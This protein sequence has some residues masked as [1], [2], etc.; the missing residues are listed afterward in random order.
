MIARPSPIRPAAPL[1]AAAVAACVALVT[2]AHPAAATES[3]DVPLM[4]TQGA[5]APNVLII[6]DS[7]GSMAEAIYHPEYD[8]S[9]S[10]S[11]NFAALTGYSVAAT[12][13]F[14][15][16]SWNAGWPAAPT[17][18]LAASEAGRAGRYLGNYL[19]W[20]FFHATDAQRASLPQITRI[21][22]GK[23]AVQ[24]I[25]S[26]SSG[27][28]FG[29][30]RFNGSDG[31]TLVSPLGSDV[32]SILTAMDGIRADS[33]TPSAET[34]VDALEYFQ[35]NG[36]GA[37]IQYEC[38]D[39]SIVFVTDGYPTQDLDV[40]AYIGDPDHD[41]AEPGNCSSIGAPEPDGNN[42]S[43]WMDD[44]AFYLAHQDLR[45]DLDGLQVVHTYTIGFGIDA[46]LLMN[47]AEN[48]GGIY[49]SAWD[50]ESLQASLGIVIGNI[51][52]RISAGGSVAVV[53]T[54]Q[55]SQ[56]RMYRGKFL[57]GVWR[58]YLESYSLPLSTHQTPD[59]EAGELLKQRHPADRTVYT[60][61][62]G[63]QVAFE[64]SNAPELTQPLGVANDDEAEDL[65][66]WVRGEAVSGLRD[67]NGWVLGDIVHSAPLLVG[68][69][70]E[71]FVD[72]SYQQYLADHANR[73]PV[74]YVGANDG[75]LHAFAAETGEE[76]WAYIPGAL[77]PKL[78][79]LAS[80]DYCHQ[81][82]VDLSSTAFEVQIEGIWRTVLVGGLR[83]GGDCYFALDVTDPTA[84]PQLLWE[85]SVPEIG[86][87]FTPPAVVRAHSGTYLWVGSGPDAGGAAAYA[88]INLVNGNLTLQGQLGGTLSS[89]NAMSAASVYDADWDGLS[90]YV[91]QGDLAGNLWRWDV[92]SADPDDWAY[93]VLFAGDQPIQAR[94]TLAVDED[95][96]LLVYFGTGRYVGAPDQADTEQRSFYCIRDNGLIT[97]IHD[98]D[99][100]DQTSSIANLDGKSGWR[101]NL[102]QVEGERVT[103]AATVVEGVVY[104]TSFAP[105]DIACAGGGR[106]WL[107]RV[108]YRDGSTPQDGGT[109][110][111][112]VDLGEGISS[113]P[114]I[115]IDQAQVV[116]QTSDA[117]VNLV[118]L[119]LSP[120]RIVVEGWHER[121]E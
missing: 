116:V 104:F 70:S 77:L 19:N 66:N 21:Q 105:S 79:Q 115:Q 113:K 81:T 56:G 52:S 43:S 16:R 83:T 49:Q 20:I 10:W 13:N 17:A 3:C 73:A 36:A 24:S 14:T 117:R 42:C 102:T 86:A 110:D 71:Y 87:S 50:L 68:A 33:W 91:Y 47:T 57:P 35:S 93:D 53:S 38:Q 67:R 31:G 12:G 9:V 30:M 120:R 114:V 54:E 111:R 28:R 112:A 45:P 32:P 89:A 80:P 118:D 94:P 22:A 108:A 48:G 6:L 119:S 107:Y 55:E 26:Q 37:P 109:A 63:T 11:G 8:P 90:D 15:P 2:L 72:E 78:G 121:F 62:D 74:V 95:G 29:L 76:L 100:A 1:A 25:L 59:W 92:R 7:S 60:C 41:H 34:L 88:V 44:V 96:T 85:A 75:M 64:P 51:T 97:G 84:P 99:L 82:F 39:N 18:R 65:I 4:V 5:V 23:A 61:V 106:S 46:P 98:S 101:M 27:L 103:D 69:P 40:P 58:G